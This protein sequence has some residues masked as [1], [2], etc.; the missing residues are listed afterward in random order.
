MQK[1]IYVSKESYI[2]K[3]DSY[4]NQIIV[5]LMDLVMDLEKEKRWNF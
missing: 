3:A 2:K 4:K 5:S 1:S